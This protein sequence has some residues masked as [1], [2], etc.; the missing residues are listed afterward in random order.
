MIAKEVEE[1]MRLA[2]EAHPEVR[3]SEFTVAPQVKPTEG[4]PYHEWLIEFASKPNNINAFAADIDE[5]LCAQNAYY[6]DLVNGKVLKPLN[7][8]TLQPGAFHRYMKSKGRLG[9]QNKI[10]RLANDR[11]IANELIIGLE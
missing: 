9:G 6:K 4:L 8:Y 5:A 3:L 1:A 2:V 11:K 10:P 7:I